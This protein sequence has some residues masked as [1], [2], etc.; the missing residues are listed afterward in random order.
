VSK[1]LTDS[2]IQALVQHGPLNGNRRYISEQYVYPGQIPFFSEL[3]IGGCA[4]LKKPELVQQ[5][6]NRGR[7]QHEVVE[8]VIYQPDCALSSR[9]QHIHCVVVYPYELGLEGDCSFDD[10]TDAAHKRGLGYV[11][12]DAA[13]FASL[14]FQSGW[15]SDKLVV[16]VSQ[17]VMYFKNY[18][19]G[20]ADREINVVTVEPGKQLTQ[21]GL[22]Y[23]FT[24]EV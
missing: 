23:L 9:R 10:L 8:R 3:I 18:L 14:Q 19:F 15:C 12:T 13:L 16:F 22:S 5:L 17:P 2:Q 4:S 6:K 24:R 1:K 21:P 7:L 20:L 11:P